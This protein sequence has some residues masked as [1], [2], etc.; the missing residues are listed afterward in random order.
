[1]I[2]KFQ[3]YL[4]D[5]GV[6][7]PIQDKVEHFYCLCRDMHF[8]KLFDIFID[9]Y[10][11]E[12][13]TRKYMDLS[14]FSQKFNFSVPH[15]L[16]EDKIHIATHQVWCDHIAIKVDNYDFKKANDKSLMIVQIFRE[17]NPTGFYKASQK[18]C[19]YL[20]QI[21]KKYIQPSLRNC[22]IEISSIG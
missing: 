18:N 20:V 21:L 1:M 6:T 4:K 15:F 10:L 11:T 9:D 8:G 13:R 7:K 12:D 22:E 3:K 16:T 19:E 2:P 17:I 14:F 5:I